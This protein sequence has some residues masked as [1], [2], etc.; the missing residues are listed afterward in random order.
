MSYKTH[1]AVPISERY[2]RTKRAL[3]RADYALKF[4][5]I[6]D[7]VTCGNCLRVMRALDADTDWF[8]QALCGPGPTVKW[9]GLRKYTKP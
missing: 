8:V 3:C 2:G 1:K 5:R 6:D 7:N 4:T 9:E